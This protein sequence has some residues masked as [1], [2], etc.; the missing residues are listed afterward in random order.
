MNLTGEFNGKVLAF[1]HGQYGDNSSPYLFV[2]YSV[3]SKKTPGKMIHKYAD[4]KAKIIEFAKN[5]GVT[6]F[7]TAACGSGEHSGYF[8]EQLGLESGTVKGYQSNTSVSALGAFANEIKTHL[9]PK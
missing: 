4:V 7:Y 9:F 6:R 1:V 2:Q 5:A 8:E 3:P